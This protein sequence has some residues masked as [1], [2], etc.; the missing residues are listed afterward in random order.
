MTRVPEFVRR[1]E[2]QRFDLVDIGPAES[3]AVTARDL[4]RWIEIIAIAG[5][6]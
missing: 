2:E 6:K 4:P 5:I 3:R 1:I